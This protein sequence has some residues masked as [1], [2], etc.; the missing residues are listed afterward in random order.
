MLDRTAGFA[1]TCR[2]DRHGEEPRLDGRAREER[3]VARVVCGDDECR[4]AAPEERDLAAREGLE[5]PGVRGRVDRSRRVELQLPI[6][7]RE[8]VWRQE[9]AIVGNEV[10]SGATLAI[11]GNGRLGH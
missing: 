9:D 6:V 10:E 4:I 5:V 7:D 11:P 2:V 1:D 8:R 3:I